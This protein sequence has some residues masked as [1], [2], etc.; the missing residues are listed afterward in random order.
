[1]RRGLKRL[2]AGT[3]IGLAAAAAVLGAIAGPTV[4]R[5]TVGLHDHDT[6][7]PALPEP[8]RETA[9]LIFSK[10]NGFR[11]DS[12]AASNAALA[13]IAERRGWSAV[14]TENGAVF[15]PA[16][17]ARFRA[18]IWNSASGDVLTAE[19]RAA[20]KT[21]IEAGG[22]FLGLHAA[23][24]SSHD[25]WPWYLDRLIGAHF[26]GHPMGPQFQQATLRIEDTDNPALRGF[27]PAW[28]RTDEWYSFAAS[29]R[30][31]GFRIL[32]TLDEDSYRPAFHMPPL[33]RKDL[34]MGADHPVIWFHCVGDGRALYSALG[35]SVEAYAE[36][37]HLRMLEGAMAWVAGLEGSR[38]ENGSEVR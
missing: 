13:A 11:H 17:L 8:L 12:I 9:V 3:A 25:G 15:N 23:G 34:R 38:C 27:G 31:K 10:T 19:Q 32:A 14:V 21:Y 33:P 28:V 26:I 36:P 5:V 7:P 18:V 35:H 1:M 29:P 20:F 6:V 22:G 30:A 24:D 16:Q 37:Q 4:Y 2:L